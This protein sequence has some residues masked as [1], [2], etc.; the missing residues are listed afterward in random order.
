MN[1]MALESLARKH[2]AKW[3][4]K[5]VAGI[6]TQ[7]MGHKPSATTEKHYRRH[8]RELSG[9]W[10]TRIEASNLTEAGIAFDVVQTEQ[11]PEL[12]DVGSER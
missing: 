4:P 9:L 5:K 11:E 6:V 3:L 12:L 10:H 2:W 7:I 8:P 1:R